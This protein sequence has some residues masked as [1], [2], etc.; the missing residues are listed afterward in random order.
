MFKIY[1]PRLD[2]APGNIAEPTERSYAEASAG[3]R[4]QTILV[5]E[6][7]DAVRVSAA[8]FAAAVLSAFGY[9]IMQASGGAEAPAQASESQSIGLA[10]TDGVMPNMTGPQLAA[11]LRKKRP[12]LNVLFT[13]GYT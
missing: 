10:I 8:K 3:T 1:L 6:D 11:S 12:G 7:R 13:W 2:A 5:V 4:N 9:W